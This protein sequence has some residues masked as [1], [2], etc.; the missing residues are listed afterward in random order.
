[1]LLLLRLLK[2]KSCDQKCVCV[3]AKYVA[4]AFVR[5]EATTWNVT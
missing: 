5:K 2:R 4:D 1:M 3:R